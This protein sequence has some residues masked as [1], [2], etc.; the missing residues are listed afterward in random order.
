MPRAAPVTTATLPASGRSASSPAGTSA[1]AEG[2]RLAVD[3]GRPAGQEEPHRAGERAP[4]RRRARSSRF[5]VD[6]LRAAPCRWSG[7]VRPAPAAA[8]ASAGDGASA[9]GSAEHE[10]PA[11]G[12]AA[13]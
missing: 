11:A 13:A 12:R 7:P 5:A 4:P 2:D 9:G 6:A 8:A 3:V 1:G 10:H